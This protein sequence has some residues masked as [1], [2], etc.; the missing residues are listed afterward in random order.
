MTLTCGPPP[1]DLNFTVVKS[2]EWTHM[3]TVIEKGISLKNGQSVLT[4]S[5]FFPLNDGKN[6]FFLSSVDNNDIPSSLRYFL[7]F[8]IKYSLI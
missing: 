6:V 4:L 2:V 3:G 8:N 7:I 1:E 5:S